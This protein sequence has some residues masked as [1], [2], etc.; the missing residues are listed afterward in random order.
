MEKILIPKQCNP[1]NKISFSIQDASCGSAIL[2]SKEEI[3]VLSFRQPLE[4]KKVDENWFSDPAILISLLAL[5]FSILASVA[6]IIYN[7]KAISKARKQ[8]IDDHF[9]F[10]EVIYPE[11]IKPINEFCYKILANLPSD[12]HKKPTRKKHTDI[13]FQKYREEHLDLSLN[14]SRISLVNKELCKEIQ[15]EFSKI[16]DIVTIFC[17]ENSHADLVN[18]D[19]RTETIN[20][21]FGS[22]CSILNSAKASQENM[23]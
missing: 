19:L 11:V 12:E 7:N 6:S 1:S 9:W 5:I 16:E 20:Q 8:S 18:P 10:R 21:I 22:Q 13:F 23:K 4:I 3:S 17:Y 15:L 2:E 14:I